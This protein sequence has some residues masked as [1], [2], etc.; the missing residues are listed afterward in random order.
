MD[1]FQNWFGVG[2]KGGG[3][4]GV[5]GFETMEGYVSNLG[6]PRHSHELNVSSLRLGIGLGASVG[7]TAIL[8]YNCGN[9]QNLSGT[10]SEDWSINISF[11][12][13]WSDIVKGLANLQFYKTAAKLVSWSKATPKDIDTIRNSMSYLWTTADM[14][15]NKP[16]L[17]AID[18]PGT[19]IGLEGSIHKLYGTIRIG[20]L[21]TYT[22]QS[23]TAPSGIRRG[24]I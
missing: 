15:A 22:P 10:E 4:L 1:H 17:V 9:I 19:G 3:T 5:A 6:Y 18:I 16:Q 13:K 7:M 21:I 14:V 20:E 11:G 2:I 12:E 24:T 23:E 8:V